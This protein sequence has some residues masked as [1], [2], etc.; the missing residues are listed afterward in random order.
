[1]VKVWS[2]IDPFRRIK[3][4][5]AGHTEEAI[6]LVARLEIP[7]VRTFIM[8]EIVLLMSPYLIIFALFSFSGISSVNLYE[9]GFYFPI[10]ASLGLV[11]WTAFD[12]RRSFESKK[13]LNS[14]LDEVDH[15]E[16][17]I[18][19]YGRDLMWGLR[20]LVAF[21]EGLKT[22]SKNISDSVTQ[23]GQKKDRTG[24]DGAPD[25]VS[26]DADFPKSLDSWKG[27]SAASEVLHKLSRAAD[28]ILNAPILLTQALIDKLL[29][30]LDEVIE[31]HFRDFTEKPSIVMLTSFLWTLIPVTWLLALTYLYPQP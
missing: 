1:M 16:N 20:M 26:R 5:L 23:S 7:G 9:R 30:Q 13:T 18:G 21:R 11:I 31:S 27:P 28:A 29:G 14:L 10:I 12:A 22:V 24:D 8:R 3:R 6:D 4:K 17:R 25:E 19:E 2:L 15:F